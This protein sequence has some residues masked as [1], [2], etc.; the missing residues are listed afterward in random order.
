MDNQIRTKLTAILSED[1]EVQQRAFLDLLEEAERPV[2]WAY[3]VWDQ[4]VT[5]L[6]SPN[7]RVRAISAQLLCSLARKSDPDK[8]I[9]K[10]FPRLMAVTRDPRFVTARHTLQNI[11]KVGAAG[12]EQKQMLLQALSGRYTDCI[13]EK[14]YMLVR[15]DIIAALKKL[16]DDDRDE[17]IRFLALKLIA[18]EENPRNHQKNLSLWKNRK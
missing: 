1:R 17:K 18:L 16:Y 2:E 13:D 3:D 6:A 4:L 7:N 9:L 11:W 12:G 14:N 10:D 8:R 5:G 15:Y